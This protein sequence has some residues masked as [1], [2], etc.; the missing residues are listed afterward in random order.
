M[1]IAVSVVM[2]FAKPGTA[3]SR[4]CG[5]AAVVAK[6]EVESTPVARY[7]YS[8]PG[9]VRANYPGIVFDTGLVCEQS[10]CTSQPRRLQDGS[11]CSSSTAAACRSRY[12]GYAHRCPFGSSRDGL[13]SLGATWDGP[14]SQ[15]VGAQPEAAVRLDVYI[16]ELLVKVN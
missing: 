14:R 3:G 7:L 9:G 5:V 16:E 6:P 8:V 13:G 10:S 1:M 4:D 11:C 12:A 2:I 15:Q